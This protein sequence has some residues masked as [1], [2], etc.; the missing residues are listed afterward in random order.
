MDSIEERF[1]KRAQGDGGRGPKSTMIDGDL[2]LD[3][4]EE[5]LL[6]YEQLLQGAEVSNNQQEVHFSK[7]SIEALTGVVEDLRKMVGRV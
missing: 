5:L 6:S 7:G 1:I 2:F 3:N 4:L